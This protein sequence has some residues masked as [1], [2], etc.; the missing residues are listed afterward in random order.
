MFAVVRRKESGMIVRRASLA[1]RGLLDGWATELDYVPPSAGSGH[2]SI[3][4]YHLAPGGGPGPYHRHTSS[5]S[6]YFLLEGSLSV[7]L[8][9]EVATLSPGDLAFIP[10]GVAHAV[11]NAGETDAA[12]VEIYGP[13]AADFVMIEDSSPT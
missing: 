10:A 4:V 11:A 5:D 2:L 1:P 9:A 12:F 3:R 7:R 13:G 8:V 6:A